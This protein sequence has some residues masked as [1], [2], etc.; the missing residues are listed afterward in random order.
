MYVY[1]HVYYFV[2]HPF[3]SCKCLF[4][5]GTLGIDLKMLINSS[6][7]EKHVYFTRGSD[8]Y[9]GTSSEI[10]HR[11]TG[12]SQQSMREKIIHV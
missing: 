10:P 1:M 6:I 12:S 9:D 5:H 7:N 11:K 4:I 3:Y 8:A 2:R